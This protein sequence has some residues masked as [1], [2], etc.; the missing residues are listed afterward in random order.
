MLSQWVFSCHSSSMT[1]G[2]RKKKCGF[3]CQ[4]TGITLFAMCL[5]YNV[6]HCTGRISSKV[7]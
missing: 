1:L 4:G 2:S 3:Q 7:T 6:Y 5:S